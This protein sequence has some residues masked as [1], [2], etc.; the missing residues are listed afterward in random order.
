M[1]ATDRVDTFNQYLEV[2]WKVRDMFVV[3]FIDAKFNFY[4]TRSGFVPL[5]DEE[6][7]GK[8]AF[9]AH[10]SSHDVAADVMRLQTIHRAEH[11][12]EQ[13]AR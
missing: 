11:D 10:D 5:A 6:L 3:T 12:L 7:L 4:T 9:V 13:T 1:L 2:L 8:T